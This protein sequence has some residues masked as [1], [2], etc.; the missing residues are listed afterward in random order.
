MLGEGNL[1]Q[2]L[3]GPP[4]WSCGIE[5]TPWY[6]EQNPI[7]AKFLGIHRKNEDDLTYERG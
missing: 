4:G 5:I 3:T 6:T 7:V 2:K 1:E